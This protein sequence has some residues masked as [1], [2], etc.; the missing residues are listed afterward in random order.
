MLLRG[1]F[2]LIIKKFRI[3][4]VILASGSKYFLEVFRT[5]D[6]AILTSID[7]PMPIKTKSN[8]GGTVIDEHV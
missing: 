5:S 2:R 8:E 6:T 1:K 4:K 7:I 3:H